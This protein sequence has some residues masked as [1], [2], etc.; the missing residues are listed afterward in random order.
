MLLTEAITCLHN[1]KLAADLQGP[2]VTNLC[3]QLNMDVNGDNA[4]IELLLLNYYFDEEN[5]AERSDQDLMMITDYTEF[6]SQELCEYLCF[7]IDRPD[8]LT[9]NCPSTKFEKFGV[10]NF[11]RDDGKELPKACAS[12]VGIIDLFNAEMK[13]LEMPLAFRSLD[14]NPCLMAYVL[15]DTTFNSLRAVNALHFDEP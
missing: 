4:N 10:L 5:G 2:V 7:L 15:P 6:Q 13:E 11:V 14:F 1:H 3:Q 8:F 12:A 9:L